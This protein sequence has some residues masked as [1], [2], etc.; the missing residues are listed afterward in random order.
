MA[1]R[2]LPLSFIPPFL[3]DQ[4]LYSWVTMFHELS[5]NASE[6]ETLIQ[7]F[8]SDKAGHQFYIPSQERPPCPSNYR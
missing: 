2:R 8:G 4:T 1:A 3:P 7:L 5:G 6:E